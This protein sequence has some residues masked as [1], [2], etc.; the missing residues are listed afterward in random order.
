MDQA[1]IKTLDRALELINANR[2]QEA[3]SLL[4][5]IIR[6]DPNNERAWHMLSFVLADREKQIYAL[7][8][9]LH[10]NPENRAARS[11]LSRLLRT[12]SPLAPP[13]AVSAPTPVEKAAS[14][15]QTAK[16]PAHSTFSR[17][18]KYTVGRAAMLLL[19]VAVGVYLAIVVINYGGYI[20]RIAQTQINESLNFVS[21]SMRDS[22]PEEVAKA[23]E[24]MR[25]AMEEAAGLHEPFLLRCVRWW[26]RALTLDWG[27]A[28]FLGIPLGLPNSSDDVRTVI[29]SR[30]PNT[31]LLAGTAN[32]VIF[33]T[34]ISLALVISKKHG[35]VLDRLI[36]TLSPISSVPNWVYGILLTVIFAGELHLLPFGGMFDEFPPAEKIGYIPIV[37][38]HMILPV[39]AIFL[40]VFFQTVYS[41]RTFFLIHSGEDYLEMAKAQ[42]LPAGMIERRYVLKPVLP[43]I[44]T[45]FTLMLITFWQGILVLELFFRWPGIGFLFIQAIKLNDRGVSV[46]LIVIFAFLLAISVFLLDL[47]YV[48]VDPRVRLGSGGQTIRPVARHKRGRP[49]W[50]LRKEKSVRPSVRVPP[51]VVVDGPYAKG[52]A[53][54]WGGGSALWRSIRDLK[55]TLREIARYPSAVVG[56][57]IIVVLIGISIYTVIAIPYKEA[58]AY[59]RPEAVEKYQIPQNALPVWVNFFRK[60]DLPATIIQ[61]SRNGTASKSVKPR[62]EGIDEV[63]IS[64][65]F[66]YPYGGFPQDMTVHFATRYNV[67]R[68]FVSLTWLTPDGREL[69]LGNFSVVSTQA[70]IASQDTPSRYADVQN[71]R[72]AEF[73]AGKGGYPA[74]QVLFAD[75]AADKSVPLPG[76]YTLRID[77]LTF[78]EGS[79][80][81]AE[82]VLYGQVYGLAGT[83]HMRRDL[84]VALL[85]G[86]PIA[87]AFGFLGAIATSII[88]MIIAAAGSWLDGWVDN[89]IQRLTEVNMMLPALP[90]AI[91]VFYLYSNSVWAILGVMILLSIFG[92]AIKNYRAAFLQ[93]KESPYIEAARAY[94]ASHWRIIRH[95]LVPRILP[96][97]I[98]QLVIL[99]PTYVF[100]EATLAY[101][102]I[103]DPRLPT[104]GKVVYDALTEG[105]FQGYYYWVLEPIGLMMVTGLAFAMVGFALDS[106]LNPRLRRM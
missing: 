56:L 66:N 6:R 13:P 52:K 4:A 67:K 68:P 5:A 80:L 98:P 87:L 61:D 106:V 59:W 19:M 50:P 63:T 77:G 38:K 22:S 105:A 28:N 82:M 92:S 11:Q 64:F 71:L 29:L 88:S 72:R 18:A 53:P 103:S 36:I 58:V 74:V 16:K 25:W 101:L 91:M 9:V 57:V 46:G 32:L 35:G 84:M 14:P 8:R 45:S 97:L 93:V 33:F 27:K 34:S 21:L 70:W 60:D 20:D 1:T 31:L 73:L 39:A 2:F 83:D 15:D 23:T 100:F 30:L 102:N 62:S 79:D 55:P 3:G 48:L 12:A 7:Q 37:L 10:I 26:Y 75:P 90:L 81:D 96:L 104:W 65:T 44:V 78:E 51:S 85:W 47:F 17:V 89:L 94:G 69:D 99:I 40:S 43:Y 49:L 86:T 24:E 41:W 76:N 42:G 95:Y 54:L